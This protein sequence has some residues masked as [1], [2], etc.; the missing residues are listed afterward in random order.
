[1]TAQD[2]AHGDLVD[3]VAQIRQGALDASVTP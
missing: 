3:V 1:M 2:I